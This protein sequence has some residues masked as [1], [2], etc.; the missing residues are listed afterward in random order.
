MLSAYISNEL[1]IYSTSVCTLFNWLIHTMLSRMKRHS[2]AKHEQT[3]V[4]AVHICHKSDI[5]ATLWIIF[6]FWRKSSRY[7]YH[8]M[9]TVTFTVPQSGQFEYIL[10]PI[11]RDR[12]ESG[13]TMGYIMPNGDSTLPYDDWNCTGPST[14]RFSLTRYV[15]KAMTLYFSHPLLCRRYSLQAIF[16][17]K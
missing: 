4:L 5:Q 16:S 15:V 9:H 6:Q 7:V 14:V 2:S 8:L 13:D 17:G 3:N 12:L 11:Q 10:P 1:P